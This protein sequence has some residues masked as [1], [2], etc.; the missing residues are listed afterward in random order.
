MTIPIAIAGF[1]LS[2]LVGVVTTYVFQKAKY[3]DSH[4]VRITNINEHKQ[5][6]EYK[7]ILDNEYRKGIDEGAK[8]A[9]EKL[10]IFYEPFVEITDSFFK[11]TAEIGYIMQIR[12]SGL[13]IGGSIKRVT[14]REE[15]FKEENVNKLIETAQSVVNNLLLTIDPLGIPKNFVV[16]EPKVCREKSPK[17]SVS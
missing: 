2:F 1:I 15:K 6:E 4:T 14:Q 8:K 16:Q 11:K 12:Y 5:T 3:T 17:K 7:A 13:P 9:S 10:S